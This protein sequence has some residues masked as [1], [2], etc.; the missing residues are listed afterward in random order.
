MRVA[1]VKAVVAGG[2]AWARARGCLGGC[3]SYLRGCGAYVRGC[4]GGC[5]LGVLA[6]S[7]LTAARASL[8]SGAMS[9]EPYSFLSM[10]REDRWLGVGL[11]ALWMWHRFVCMTYDLDRPRV[12]MSLES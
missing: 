8:P 6:A 12:M 4:L 11:L 7:A 3:G 5:T 2:A 9:R 10:S 1:A